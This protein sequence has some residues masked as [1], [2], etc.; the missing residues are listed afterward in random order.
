M[1]SNQILADKHPD[2][3]AESIMEI[4]YGGGQQCFKV[5]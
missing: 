4:D 1:I 3:A 5:S 2:P